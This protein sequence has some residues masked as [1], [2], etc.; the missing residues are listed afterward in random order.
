MNNGKWLALALAAFGLRAYHL[1]ASLWYDEAFSAWLAQLPL[2]RL[3][4]ATLG[5][6]HPPLYYFA[7]WGVNR[8]LGHSEAALRLPSLLAGM[9]L[10]CLVVKI[11]VSLGLSSRSVTVAAAITLFSPF[12]IYYSQEARG[13]E[14]LMI[15]TALTAWGLLERR[16]WLAMI[17]S[18]AACYWHNMAVIFVGSVWLAAFVLRPAK[19]FWISG[20][21]VGVGYLPM[22]LWSVYQAQTISNEYWIL[23]IYSPGRLIATLDDLLF[24]CPSNPF[25][26]ATAYVTS[27]TLLMIGYDLVTARTG[28]QLPGNTKFLLIAVVL[29]LALVTIISLAWQPVLITRTMSPL[30]PFFYLLVACSVTKT[31]RR[32][33]IWSALAGVVAASIILASLCSVNVGRR[34]PDNAYRTFYGQYRPGDGLYHANTGSYVVSKYYRPETKQ[35]VWPQDT[36]LIGGLTAQTRQAMGMVEADF[37]TVA[38]QADRWWL[39]YAHA[40]TTSLAEISYIDHI[41]N[42]YPSQKIKQLRSD[43]T[44]DSWL[45]LIEPDCD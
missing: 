17:C 41:L 23:P 35:A 18:L 37:E 34:W 11:G 44:V 22:L 9:L 21:I 20:L 43:S 8:I 26:F 27:L 15:L 3:L 7:L 45:V 4:V 32:L 40:P 28:G 29:P 25:V 19:K 12:Q 1:T 33:V 2:K 36:S 16:W 38:C 14:L 5:D 30:A 13:Y 31:R 10:V 6:V 39:L 24:F 42:D